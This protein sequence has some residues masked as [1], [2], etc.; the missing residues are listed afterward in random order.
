MLDLDE[1]DR[2]ELLAEVRTHAS[3][4]LAVAAHRCTTGQLR[5]MVE[6]MRRQIAFYEA[7]GAKDAA[8]TQG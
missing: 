2:E 6:S 1:M 3:A 5:A 7:T 8:A 4:S